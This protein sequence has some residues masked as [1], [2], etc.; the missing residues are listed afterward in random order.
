ML[1]EEFVD[2]CVAAWESGGA[3]GDQA[4]WVIDVSAESL[5]FSATDTGKGS[6]VGYSLDV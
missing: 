1:V 2:Y 6:M 5:L 3:I 4:G